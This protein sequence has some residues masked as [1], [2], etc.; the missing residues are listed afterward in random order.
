[1]AARVTREEILTILSQFPESGT[2]GPGIKYNPVDERLEMWSRGR[3]VGMLEASVFWKS[4]SELWRNYLDR[5]KSLEFKKR[6]KK[7]R[8]G[9]IKD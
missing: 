4:D 8:R 9:N 1:M 5:W 6:N 2:R 7:R 3:L